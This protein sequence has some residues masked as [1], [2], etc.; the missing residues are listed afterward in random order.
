MD[1]RLGERLI[2][3][4]L[5]SAEA[6]DQALE[7]QQITGHRLGDCLVEL[8]LVAETALLRVLAAE[9]KTRFVSAEKLAQTKVPQEALDRI[10][11]RMAEARDVLPIAVDLERRLLSVVV[12]EPQ[13]E[14]LVR[15]IA[16]TSRMREIVAFV[17]TRATIQAAIRRYYYGDP[18]A[19]TAVQR[20]ASPS[21]TSLAL[22]RPAA[23]PEGPDTRADRRGP[24]GSSRSILLGRSQPGDTLGS[25]GMIREADFVETLHVFLDLLEGPSPVFR[26]HSGGVARQSSSIAGRIGLTPR[27]TISTSVAAYLHDLGKPKEAHLTLA[28]LAARPELRAS[29]ARLARAPTKLFEMVHLEAGV[30]ASLA[31]LYEFFDGSGVPGRAKGEDISAGARI[32]AAVDTFFDLTRNPDNPLGRTLSKKQALEWLQARSGTLFD[33]LVVDALAAVQS[34][35]LLRQRLKNDGRKILVADP[36]EA[37]RVDLLDALGRLG[38]D[39][40]SLAKLDGIV[41][42]ALSDSADAVVAG[43]G[44]G[45]GELVALAQ[46]LHERPESASVPFLVLGHPTDPTSRERLL[47]SGIHDFI[48]LPLVPGEAAHTIRAAYLDRIENGGIGHLVRGG[49]EEVGAR[50]LLRLLGTGQKSGRLTVTA[51]TNEGHIQIERG[52]A[53]YASFGDERGEAALASLSSL[54]EASFLYD[55]EAVLL[56]MP[57]ADRDLELVVR[58]L[59]RPSG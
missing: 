11:V 34:G 10:P 1:Q 51:G 28:L 56:E 39:V 15:E 12:A 27:E 8:G 44:Y 14:A 19:F 5:V 59:E 21:L 48:P 55:P 35:D 16:A 33:P 46:F 26:G 37:V 13:N 24:G 30:N 25:R 20:G 17:G 41:D 36:D 31:Q 32:I 42:A 47:D 57:N 40:H 54:A 23:A 45:V 29:A 7:H 6:V 58:S 18:T 49:F 22:A 9:L 38:L 52:R 2:E 50:D 43:L 4:G 3:A 53:I